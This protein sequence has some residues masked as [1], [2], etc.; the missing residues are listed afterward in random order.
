MDRR[1]VLAMAAALAS[2]PVA[3]A[4][5]ANLNDAINK[6]GQLRMLSQRLTKAYLALGLDVPSQKV[7][8]VINE[9]MARFDRLSVELNAFAPGGE[10]RA[11]YGK[12]T[13]LWGQYK[14]LLVGQAPSRDGAASLVELDS[15]LLVLAN[16]GVAQLEQ[17]SGKPAGRL[18]NLAGR[19]R[20]LSQRAAKFYLAQA[21]K[22][23]VPHAEAEMQK[24]RTEFT[25]ALKALEQ[26]PEAS[27]AIHQ[28]LE[29][30]RQQ[31]V[32][33]ELA[34][35]FPGNAAR[36]TENVFV[37]SENV[38]GVMEK[39]TGLYARQTA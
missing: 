36:A 14:T 28:E 21:W 4:Q 34:L 9:S 12:L 20:M 1:T 5:V 11:T 38:L 35:A 23:P 7:Q 19:Q 30:A 25:A 18:V 29:L 15:K 32:F 17:L 37:L 13:T 8:D 6:A 16:E 10:A 22:A 31:W 33:F 24:A 3:I 2:S 27:S 26:A 39:V